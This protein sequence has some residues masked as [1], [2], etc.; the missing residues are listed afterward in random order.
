MR[1]SAEEHLRAIAA[2]EEITKLEELIV[3]CN[4]RRGQAARSFQELIAAGYL[5]GLPRDPSGAPYVFEAGGHVRLNPRSS[6]D[7]SLLH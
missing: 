1:K 7:L 6:V 3:L 5:R 4:S 2:E